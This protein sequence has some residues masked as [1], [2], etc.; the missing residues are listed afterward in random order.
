MIAAIPAS[1]RG[2]RLNLLREPIVHFFA[3]AALLFALEAYFSAGQKTQIVVDQETAE[4]LIRQREDLEL[5]VLDGR[6]RAE[7]VD[8]YVEDEILYNEAYRRGLDRGDSR[9]RRNM[10]LKMRGLI[11]G[12]LEVPDDA[13]LKAYFEENPEK[14]IRPA[15]YDI[16][17][18]YFE[19]MAAVPVEPD[20]FLEQLQGG[21]EVPGAGSEEIPR[22][23]MPRMTR[24]F[25]IGSFGPEA[26]KAIL[27]IEDDAWHG[28]FEA[29]QG[30]HYV[31]ILGRVPEARA[32]FDAVRNYLQGDWMMERS[33]SLIR[34]EVERVAPDYEVLIEAEI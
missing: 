9:M 8:A 1:A 24:T 12:A 7:V 6:E 33:R 21:L 14:F 4:F 5:R 28:P 23:R 2:L 19:S 26:G 32:D 31:R 17:Q 30:V 10:I 18:I 22:R 11:T 29:V 13:E 25:I 34:A 27:A 20:V 15:R 3:L 16:E